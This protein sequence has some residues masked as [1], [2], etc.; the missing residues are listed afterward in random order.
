MFNLGSSLKITHYHKTSC[1]TLTKVYN[2]YMFEHKT[3]HSDISTWKLWFIIPLIIYV[4]II[5]LKLD[6]KS[7]VFKYQKWES[8]FCNSL[9]WDGVLF[10]LM[11]ILTATRF[12]L[13]ASQTQDIFILNN[14]LWDDIHSA[15]TWIVVC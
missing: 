8:C 4:L 3:C 14:V 9:T 2:Q 6:W 7:P 12:H 13:I 5:M 15:A 11:K 1:D 10:F